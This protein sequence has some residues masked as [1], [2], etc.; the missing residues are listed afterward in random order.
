MTVTG[1]PAARRRGVLLLADLTG[2]TG[3]LQGVADAHRDLIVDSDEPP[4]AYAVVSHLL[5]TIS[6]S[7]APTF[8]L[9]KLEGDAIFAVADEVALPGGAVL[10]SLRR[11]Y[12]AFRGALGTAAVQWT[13]TCDACTRIGELDLKFVVH[14]G[15]WVAQRIAGHE[16]LL[17]ADVNVVHRL[18]KNH[19]RELVGPVPYALVTDAAV[20]ALAMPTEGMVA[21]EE[22][23]DGAPPIPVHVLAL[24]RGSTH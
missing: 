11:S 10:D 8:R 24:P 13:C 20:K 2:Y 17:G 16:E 5:D 23:Y 21:G 15:S 9:A 1:T 4:P 6:A 12:A 22:A 19:A 7:I 18:L 3:F 14:H